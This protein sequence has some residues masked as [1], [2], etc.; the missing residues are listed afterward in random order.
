MQ[1]RGATVDALATSSIWRHSRRDGILV[2]G[3]VAHAG[4]LASTVLVEPG[5]IAGA[6]L[7]AALAVALWWNGNTVSHHFMHLPFFRSPAANAA[8]SVFLSLLLAVPQTL[9][10]EKHFAHHAGRAVAYRWGRQTGVEAAAVLTL[11]LVMLAAAPESFVT[12][13]VPSVLI[14]MGLGVIHGHFEHAPAV[15]S[16]Y[17]SFYNRLLFNDGFHV[18]HHERPGCHWTSLPVHSARGEASPFPPLVRWLEH[19]SLEGLERLTLESPF[20]Q[21]FVLERHER[22]LRQLLPAIGS[23]RTV[24]V[25][26][27][28]LFPRT[29]IIL[30]QLLPEARIRILDLSRLNLETARRTLAG[31]GLA[32]GIDFVCGR[33]ETGRVGTGGFD[34]CRPDAP[35]DLLVTPLSLAGDRDAIYANPPARYVLVHDWIWRRGPAVSARVSWLLLKRINLLRGQCRP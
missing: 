25:V 11:W 6:L 14:G 9:W 23:V 15:R 35:G 2:A 19:L 4:L 24:T 28:G 34:T 33:F 32:S 7:T 12:I 29:A 30:K 20:L 18:E 22:A 13:Y 21:R 10:R 16:Y 5:A 27:G 17:G 26:G 1:A 8:Y 31:A 3:S